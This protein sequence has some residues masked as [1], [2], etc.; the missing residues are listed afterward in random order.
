[1]YMNVNI[2]YLPFLEPSIPLHPISEYIS[3]KYCEHTIDK[4]FSIISRRSTEE[5]QRTF[6]HNGCF[7]CM[8]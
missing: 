6:Y 2:S 4:Y 5:S 1:M 7:Y 8:G 3:S